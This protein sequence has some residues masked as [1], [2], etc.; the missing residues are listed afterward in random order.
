MKQAYEKITG[1]LLIIA[2][3]PILLYGFIR[4]KVKRR[5]CIE[6][7]YQ[8]MD[9]GYIPV[10]SI[11]KITLIKFGDSAFTAKVEL[12]NSKC[13]TVILNS[14][15]KQHLEKFALDVVHDYEI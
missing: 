11:K 12:L 7:I 10:K 3:S 1:C 4:A 6:Y 13:K 8:K 15:Q 5:D 14:E 9:L 2:L